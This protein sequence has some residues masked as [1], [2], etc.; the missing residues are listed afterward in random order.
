MRGVGTT[1]RVE[2]FPLVSWKHEGPRNCAEPFMLPVEVWG[3]EP[4]A[5]RVRFPA[6]TNQFKMLQAQS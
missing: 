6:E 2:W 1:D 3:I 4:Q 5:S